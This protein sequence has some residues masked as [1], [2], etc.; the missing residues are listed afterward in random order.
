MI[1]KLIFYNNHNNGDIHFTREFVRDIV[2]KTNYDEY[3]FL[4]KRSPKLLMDIPKLQH[5]QLN[6]NCKIDSPFHII[7]NETYI[8]THLGVYEIFVD[9]VND[10]SLPIFYDYFQII[11]NKLRVPMEKKKHYLPVIDYKQFEISGINE[12]IENNRAFSKVIVCNGDVYSNQ[13]LPIDFKAL[14][15]KLADE[16]PKTHFILTDKK[17]VIEREN[18]LYT[19][20]IIKA[21][22]DL[23]EI[24]YLST[25]CT[26]IIGRASGPY[27]FTEVKENFDDVDKTF[28]FIC[29]IFSDGAW[30]DQTLCSKVWINNYEFDNIYET[31][32]RELLKQNNYNNIVDVVSKDNKIIITPFEDAPHKIRIDFY[33]DKELLYSYKTEFKKGIFHWITPHGYYRTGTI[34]KCKFYNDETNQYLFQKIV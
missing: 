31:I 5:G 8:N 20:D 18:V 1:N 15:E 17:D 29:N 16:F 6:E 27:S 3:Y 32:K 33:Q 22:A 21:G 2:Q 14:I 24:S 7:N 28:I 11:F 13:S 12:Y 10:V 26:V 9:K 4:H 30:Y 23:N 34:V 19:S 25:F